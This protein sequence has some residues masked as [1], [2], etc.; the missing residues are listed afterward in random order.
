MAG[1]RFIYRQCQRN[2]LQAMSC[3][4]FT[5][6]IVTPSNTGGFFWAHTNAVHIALN[7]GTTF[8][9]IVKRVACGIRPKD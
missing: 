3:L 2:C 4:I 9:A 1:G 7:A 6:T 8:D 5:Y